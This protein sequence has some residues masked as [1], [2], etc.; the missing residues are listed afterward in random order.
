MHKT[1]IPAFVLLGAFILGLA[2]RTIHQIRTRVPSDHGKWG[3]LEGTVVLFIVG[4][5]LYAYAY[6][7]GVYRANE[8]LTTVI[9]VAGAFFVLVISRISHQTIQS[10]QQLATL[11]REAITDPLMDIYNRRYLDR[12]LEEEVTRANRYGTAL[13]VLL[14]DIDHFK[15]VND[16]LGHDAGDRVLRGLGELLK[17]SV[18]RSDVLGRF[19]GEE[20]LLIL[21]QTGAAKALQLAEKLRR[22]IEQADL[23]PAEESPDRAPARCTVSIGVA[24]FG[25]RAATPEHLLQRVDMA[26]YRAKAEGRNRVCD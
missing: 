23:L 14:L 1:L 5:I 13:S 26:L 11:Q 8:F 4:Y 19:G 16:T 6:T 15:R 17:R 10:L 7:F 12:K 3:M 21:P 20:L 18:R 22:E 25:A 9:F 24:A 2:L